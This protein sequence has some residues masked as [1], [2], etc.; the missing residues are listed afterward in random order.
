MNLSK[1]FIQLKSKDQEEE[2]KS[3]K[4]VEV[5]QEEMPKEMNKLQS[6]SKPAAKR[7]TRKRVRAEVQKQDEN[8]GKSL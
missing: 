7:M 1:N 8:I 2:E 5:Q 4:S 6:V 3:Q